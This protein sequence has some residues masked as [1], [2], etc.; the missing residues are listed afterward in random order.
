MFRLPIPSPVFRPICPVLLAAVLALLPGC[1]RPVDCLQCG[2]F[3]QAGG[4]DGTEILECSGLA[5]SRKNPGILW[6]HNDSGDSARIFAVEEDGSLRGVYEL[7]GALAVDW[8]DMSRGPCADPGVADC[9]Y[10]GD[11]GDN[12]QSRPSVQVY[13]VAEPLVPPDGSPAAEVLEAVERFDAAY[14]DG[15]HDAETLL[16]DPDSGIP[17]IV[18]KSPIQ[19]TG[20]YRFPHAPVSGE[21]VV[22]ERVVTLDSRAF[23]TGGDVAEDGSRVVLRDYLSAFDYPRRT[24][25]AFEEI[26]SE[27]PCLVPLALEP[28]G[29]A[30]AVS[31]SGLTLY[32]AS[33]GQAGP[34]HKASCTAE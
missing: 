34:I 29:E 32:T 28:Q 10:V 27:T 19:E 21:S 14:P 4:F 2:T 11:I 18:T 30:L 26:F 16:V 31:P 13:R 15:A 8:E 12:G 1:P 7:A 6:V 20:V 22:L 5:A 24:A 17:Y 33:E 3:T 23:L 9:L 25:G